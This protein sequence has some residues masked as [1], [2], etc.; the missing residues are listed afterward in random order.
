[1]TALWTDAG[2]CIG[3]PDRYLTVRGAPPGRT[4]RPP[5]S[6]GT[7]GRNQGRRGNHAGGGSGA[8]LHDLRLPGFGGEDD[9]GVLIRDAAG[10]L[11][12]AA[13]LRLDRESRMARLVSIRCASFRTAAAALVRIGQQARAT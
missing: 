12:G 9:L 4:L 5:G 3:P 7:S 11:V 10:E 13:L 8:E 6:G 2:R 1:M